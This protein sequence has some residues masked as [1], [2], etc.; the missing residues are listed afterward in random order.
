MYAD[1][2]FYITEYSGIT[3]TSE[4]TYSYYGARA[5][6]YI[7]Q[8]TYGRAT[9]DNINVKKCEC[10]L[11]ELLY[12]NNDSGNSDDREVKSE[13]LG[14]WSRT[15]AES[16]LSSSDLDAKIQTTIS[17]YLALTGMLYCGQRKWK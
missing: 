12:A 17:R 6:E 9:S 7:E 14:G 4:E 1:Y 5:A 10:R 11:A 13:S 16:K 2:A 15:Y 3:I 8:A